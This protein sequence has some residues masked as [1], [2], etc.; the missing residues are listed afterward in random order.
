M[1]MGM[2]AKL[3]I[4]QQG[5]GGI[6][7]VLMM[8]GPRSGCIVYI[9]KALSFGSSRRMMASFRLCL[10]RTITATISQDSER[11]LDSWSRK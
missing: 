9:S 1:R 3:G 7:R 6:V 10:S 11:V 4:D 2:T 5:R 8:D